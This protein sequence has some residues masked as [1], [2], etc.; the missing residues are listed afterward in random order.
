MSLPSRVLAPRARAIGMG[1]FFTVFYAGMVAGPAVGG[2]AATR[3]GSAAA[4][5]DVGAASLLACVLFVWI[6]RR[7][8]RQIAGAPAASIAPE[9]VVQDRISAERAKG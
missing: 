1:A 8:A 4:A 6:F 9:A 3:A 2:W 7:L 5:F